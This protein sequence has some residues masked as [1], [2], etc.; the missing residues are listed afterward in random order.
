MKVKSLMYGLIVG[1]IVAGAGSLLSAPYSGKELRGKLKDKQNDWKLTLEDLK[2]RANELKE[3]IGTLSQESKETVLQLSKDLQ[4]S[5]KEWQISTAPNNERLQKEIETVRQTI[6][7]LEKSIDL[8][9][10][11]QSK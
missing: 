5:I 7:D 4:A 6:E 8:P 2:E 10:S 3:S 11:S 9:G 1:G